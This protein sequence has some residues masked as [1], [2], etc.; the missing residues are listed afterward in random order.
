[1]FQQIHT[2]EKGRANYIQLLAVRQWGYTW[3]L[4]AFFN[5]S[6]LLKKIHNRSE[7]CVSEFENEHRQSV[8]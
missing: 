3:V 8:N 4:H 1:M 7:L 5:Q 2:K 6:K